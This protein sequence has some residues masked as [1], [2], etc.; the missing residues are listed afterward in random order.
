MSTKDQSF[1]EAFAEFAGGTATP[2]P[3]RNND[4]LPAA[5]LD[6][7]PLA[8]SK[9]EGEVPDEDV[10]PLRLASTADERDDK[11]AQGST[12]EGETTSKTGDKPADPLDGPTFDEWLAAVPEA[13]RARFQPMAHKLKSDNGRVAAWQRL[14]NEGR[15][16]EQALAKRIAELEAQVAAAT[17]PSGNVDASDDGGKADALSEFPELSAAVDNRIQSLRKKPPESTPAANAGQA[18]PKGDAQDQE[19]QADPAEALAKKYEELG[20]LHPDYE[21]IQESQVFATWARAQPAALQKLMSS[22]EVADAAYVLDQF[23]RDWKAARDRVAAEKT[24]AKSDRLSM[25]TPVRGAPTRSTVPV[26]DFES[27]FSHFAKQREG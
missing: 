13:Q 27:A 23:K 17:K 22:N 6:A 3:E 11:L 19:G 1:D 12:K 9:P 8:P 16:K 24:Q 25:Q 15:T 10:K 14:Y 7:E 21:A 18:S 4:E 26:D 5:D 2:E 20:K